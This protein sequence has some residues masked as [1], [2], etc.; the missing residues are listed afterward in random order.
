MHALKNIIHLLCPDKSVTDV[1]NHVPHVQRYLTDCLR[2]PPAN[3]YVET[4]MVHKCCVCANENENMMITDPCTGDVVCLGNGS[5]GCGNVLTVNNLQEPVAEGYAFDPYYSTQAHF[6]SYLN[7]KGGRIKKMN[8]EVE[9]YLNK[10]SEEGMTTSEVFKDTQRSS[11]NA[12]LQNVR[13]ILG[14]DPSHIDTV[15]ALFTEY[16]RRMTRIHKLNLVLA[17]LFAIAMQDK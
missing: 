1:L 16:R 11:V 3:E 9:R 15:K 5:D 7:V 2:A 10:W 13:V 17:C 12:T 6:K 4:P 14:I 8:D